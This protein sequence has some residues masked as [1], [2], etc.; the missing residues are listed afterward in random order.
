[1][2]KASLSKSERVTDALEKE[3]LSGRLAHGERLQ[4]ESQL[5]ARFSASRNTIRKGLEGL[6]S[7]GLISTRT[8][9]GS[10]VTFNGRQ[11]DSSSGWARALARTGADTETRLRRL[12]RM[13]DPDLAKLLGLRSPSFIAVDRTRHLRKGGRTISLERSRLPYVPELDDVPLR[14]LR[15][16]SLHSTLAAAGL[17]PDHGEEWAE[18]AFLDPSEAEI[19]GAATG[20]PFLK[21]RR[22]TR[23]AGKRPIEHVTS[24]LDPAFFALHLE[25]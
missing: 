14:G 6:T 25:F 13:D 18:V 4:S 8:G 9:I 3:I 17:Y 16:G 5:V 11:I 23:T 19:M 1:M 2:R 22:V 7:R 24:L 21:L 15:E 10:F 12:E 20:A